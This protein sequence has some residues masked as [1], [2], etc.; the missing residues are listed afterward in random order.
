MT[1]IDPNTGLL[2][3]AE[4]EPWGNEERIASALERIADALEYSTGFKYMLD[5]EREA[6][7]F[8]VRTADL[9]KKSGF[10][11]TLKELE[12]DD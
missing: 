1:A 11:K 6:T 4:S 8:A 10:D 2:M 12:K 3:E 7:E 9:M 5:R